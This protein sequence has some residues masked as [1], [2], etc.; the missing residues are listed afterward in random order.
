MAD[1]GT[2]KGSRD[3]ARW[4][5]NDKKLQFGYSISDGIVIPWSTLRSLK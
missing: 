3:F 2:F 5:N 1:D 4:S